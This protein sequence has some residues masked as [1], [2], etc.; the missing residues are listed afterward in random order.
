M[1]VLRT[2]IEKN[3]AFWAKIAKANGWYVEPFYVQVWI[4]KTGSVTDSVSH[5]GLTKDIV[6]EE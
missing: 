3:R 1:K 4:D 6:V 5:I 2:E